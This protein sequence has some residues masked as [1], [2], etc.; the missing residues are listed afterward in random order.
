MK[1]LSHHYYYLPIQLRS[2][3][4]R[5]QLRTYKSWFELW[6][7]H[8]LSTIYLA[9]RSRFNSTNGGNQVEHKQ[10]SHSN[11]LNQSYAKTLSIPLPQFINKIRNSN[12][13]AA[14][15]ERT[16]W[17]PNNAQTMR[18]TREIFWF[19]IM[20]R[21][22]NHTQYWRNCRSAH[23]IWMRSVLHVSK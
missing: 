5:S 15:H 10:T 14:S 23:N 22:N 6:L 20:W 19:S 8:F 21:D 1:L 18:L 17:A 11:M 9:L 12:N 4:V 13:C 7:I 16:N 2:N 3:S